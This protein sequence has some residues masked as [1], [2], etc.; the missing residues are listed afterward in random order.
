MARE[1]P[2]L[3]KQPLEEK[4]IAT[5]AFVLESQLVCSYM[6][7]YPIYKKYLTGW[8]TLALVVIPMILGITWMHHKYPNEI[9]I[10]GFLISLSTIVVV[11]VYRSFF[12]LK[13]PRCSHYSMQLFHVEDEESTGVSISTSY[14]DQTCYVSCKNCGKV[15]ETDL[16]FKHNIF[17]K[18]IP[19]QLKDSPLD[20]K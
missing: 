13:C 4:K 14:V 11:L 10:L 3:S 2:I 9:G 6:K 8:V 1:A 20:Y 19:V 16:G 7:R 15:M 12:R 18:G 5:F 17:F